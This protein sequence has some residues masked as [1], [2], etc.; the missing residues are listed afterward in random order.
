MNYEGACNSALVYEKYAKNKPSYS[1]NRTQKPVVTKPTVTPQ[2][3][4]NRG[5]TNKNMSK[6]NT[7]PKDVI[8]FKCY[9]HGHY[10]DKC[11]NAKAFTQ[12]KWTEIQDRTGP[13]ARL[14]L[15]NGREKVVFPPTLEDEY[16]GTFK[17]NDPGV[18]EKDEDTE[19]DED[20]E[21]VHLVEEHYGMLI[22]RNFHAT[23][24]VAKSDQRENIFQTK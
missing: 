4:P 23:L 11:P 15:I 14:V 1:Y 3:K 20:V 6:A 7:T 2:N 10:K 9:G 16:E 8:C 5:E 18:M 17:V 13:R 12:K 22:R 24:R 21:L 19:S